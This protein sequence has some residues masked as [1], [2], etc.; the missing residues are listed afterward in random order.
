MTTENKEP[1]KLSEIK[2]NVNNLKKDKILENEVKLY[3]NEFPINFTKDIYIYKYHFT[4]IPEV[5]E[6]H[7]ISKI[8]KES[9]IH[10]IYGTYHHSGKCF[11]AVNEVSEAKDFKVQLAKDEGK[12]EYTL[13]VKKYAEIT[14]IIKGQ[15]KNFTQA[16][17]RIIFLIIRE[18]LTA[19]PNVKVDKDNFYLENKFK[20]IKGQNQTYY[21]HEGYKI[22]LKQTEEGLC[23]IIG[24]K[25]RVIGDLS[26]Y[27]AL[28]DSKYNYG[29]NLD[30]RIKNLIGKRFVPEGSTK[31]KVIYDI[32]KDRTPKNT[33]V[34][35]FK[36]TYSDYVTYYEKVFQKKIEYP[37]QPMIQVEYKK[38]QNENGNKYGW[39]VPE[40]C[41]LIG[42]NENDTDNPNFKKELAKY[43]QLKPDEVVK[44]INECVK[45]F[46]DKNEKKPKDDKNN[47]DEMEIKVK[48]PYNTSE[49][50]RE[51]YGLGIMTINGLTA[52]HIVKPVFNYGKQKKDPLNKVTEVGRINLKT[53]NWI[54]LYHE[55]LEDYTY[56]LL[57]D[58]NF[59]QKQLGIQMKD[60]DSNWIRMTNNNIQD[61]E[62]TVEKKMN[63]NQIEFVIFFI[64]KS[65]NHLYD[66]LKKF[67]LCEIG[68]VSQVIKFEKYKEMRNKKKQASYIS[69]ILAQIN[70]KLGGANYT[71]NLNKTITDRNI[72][73]IGI[74]FGL[75][76]SHTWKRR[77][78]GVITMIATKDKSFSKFYAQNEILECK[79]NYILKIQ[80]HISAFIKHAMIKYEKEENKKPYNIIIY[81]QGISQYSENDIK[82]EIKIIEE[83]CKTNSINYYYVVVN[84]KSSLKIFEVN[85]KK[86]ERESGVYK[87]PETGLVVL[88]KVTN[89]NRFEFYLQPQKVN[90]GSATPTSFNVIYGNMNYPELLIML[91]YWTTFIYPNWKNAV[92]IPHVLKIAE[93]YSSMTAGVTKE[94]NN[95]DICDLLPGL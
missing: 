1:N 68:Y 11:Y 47:K 16:Q 63:E 12:I 51:F 5:N 45:L 15:K 54:C 93:K 36:E 59:C 43:T 46:N 85:S 24:I 95:E 28:K 7:V 17:E 71:L 4:I 56:D 53:S 81:R 30:E 38:A 52:C 55:S 33:T 34:N 61:W 6:E 20:E 35:T 31:S 69:N 27:D 44:Q 42:L 22:S 58:I 67:S 10:E 21:I 90:Q 65:N 48:N 8:L 91:T 89:M 57:D 94:R 78:K 77:E 37:E 64:S 75:N 50:K 87:N 39:F 76:A 72:M 88:N 62:D 2:Y 32:S 70:C 9:K 14:Q 83:F 25:N 23:L 40:C 26:V 86:T 60:G 73:F 13:Q 41:K 80:E 3:I 92:R 74:D 79:K 29:K 84:M 19:N 66:G 18:I 49:K 82:S